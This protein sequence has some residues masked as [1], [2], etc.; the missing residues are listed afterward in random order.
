MR[1]K[2]FPCLYVKERGK[3]TGHRAG[4][5][6]F[7]HLGIEIRRFLGI[8]SVRILD[9]NVNGLAQLGHR[10]HGIPLF[11]IHMSQELE[12]GDATGAGN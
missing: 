2:K 3:L 10:G 7:S 9:K 1:Y 6:K 5:R 4:R 8:F 11:L 12:E